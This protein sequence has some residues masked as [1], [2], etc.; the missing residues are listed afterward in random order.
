VQI[1]VVAAVTAAGPGNGFLNDD[2]E[3]QDPAADPEAVTE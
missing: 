3:G 1:A 2:R